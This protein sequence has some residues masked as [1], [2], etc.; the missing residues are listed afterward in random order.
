MLLDVVL[1]YDCNYHCDFCTITEVMRARALDTRR[2]VQALMQGR[3][4]GADRVS[5]TGG[6]PTIRADLP[7]LVAHA[8][9]LGYRSVK[10]Q[11]NGWRLGHR[12]YLD[13]LVDAGCDLVHLSPMAHTAARHRAITGDESG[14][15]R[16]GAAVEGLVA[17][18]VDVVLDVIMKTDTL[19]DVPVLVD[20]FHAR[21]VRR[22]HLWLMSLTDRAAGLPHM[23]PRLRDVAP[24]AITC[25]ERAR[26]GGFEVKSLHVPRCFF[27]GYEDHVFDVL[28]EDAVVVTP[29][30]TF[31]LE[32]SRLTANTHVPACERCRHRSVCTGLRRDYL[33]RFGDGE[34]RPV[35]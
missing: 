9:R 5:F 2:A 14:F 35:A 3:A 34:V 1:Q 11:S 27:P 10:V 30:A 4:A 8:R 17:R 21:G 20:T 12:P 16:L 18:G 22:F 25:F 7:A 33:A 23:L 29:D 13:A 6:E 26:A 24:V 28:A 15:A 19:A 31:R 32:H